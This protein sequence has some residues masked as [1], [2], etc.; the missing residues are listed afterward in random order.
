ME[1]PVRYEIWGSA[2]SRTVKKH[3]PQ[4]NLLLPFF[5]PPF[6][7]CIV[8][9]NVKRYIYIKQYS[10][11]HR[12]IVARNVKEYKNLKC[13]QN[14][15]NFLQKPVERLTPWIVLSLYGHMLTVEHHRVCW[16]NLIASVHFS[17]IRQSL[18]R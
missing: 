13:Y 5:M 17:K 15:S 7:G 16:M 4:E 6:L 9:S 18:H 14:Y 3:R 11:S 2:V 8:K 1:N 10:N 12:T